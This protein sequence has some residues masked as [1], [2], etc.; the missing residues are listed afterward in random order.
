MDAAIAQASANGDQ[1][2][3]LAACQKVFQLTTLQKKVQLEKKL[4]ALLPEQCLAT[5]KQAIG[6]IVKVHDV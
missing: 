3:E 5:A 2:A 1:S 6:T 4:W